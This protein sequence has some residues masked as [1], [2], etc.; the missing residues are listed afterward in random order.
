MLQERT[1]LAGQAHKQL[2]G[3]LDA[4]Q[5]LHL[6]AHGFGSG[7]V[8]RIVEHRSVRITDALRGALVRTDH[9]RD[10]ECYAPLGAVGLVARDG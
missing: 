1:A 5:R 3:V 2:D 6:L 10:A 7:T 8:A 4:R 9:L